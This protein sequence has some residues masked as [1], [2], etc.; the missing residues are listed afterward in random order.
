MKKIKPLIQQVLTDLEVTH[1]PMRSKDGGYL[2]FN[3]S[4][5]LPCCLVEEEIKISPT[6]D[7]RGFEVPIMFYLIDTFGFDNDMIWDIQNVL[8]DKAQEIVAALK[9]NTDGLVLTMPKEYIYQ[10]N[11]TNFTDC[12]VSF[13]ITFRFSKC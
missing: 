4:M 5:T 8:F 10:H 6:A 12:G 7:S 1:F 2:E 11:L 3:D 9:I 13:E